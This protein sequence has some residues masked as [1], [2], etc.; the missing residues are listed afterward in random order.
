MIT[1]ES[2]GVKQSLDDYLNKNQLDIEELCIYINRNPLELG[3][4]VC[5]VHL[6]YR[7]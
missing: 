1:E 2:S 3:C 5:P 4:L 7:L 6:P